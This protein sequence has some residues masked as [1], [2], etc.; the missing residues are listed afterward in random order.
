SGSNLAMNQ[1]LSGENGLYQGISG[2]CAALDKG[3]WDLQE[4][5]I[6]QAL[7]LGIQTLNLQSV[8]WSLIHWEEIADSEGL[9]H[10]VELGIGLLLEEAQQNDPAISEWEFWQSAD[11]FGAE[12]REALKLQEKEIPKDLPLLTNASPK[13]CEGFRK[14]G[15]AEVFST[16]YLG[17]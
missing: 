16:W 6:E 15:R 12:P 2:G 13:S 17:D 9:W 10:P 4:G 8:Q 1:G 5:R 11:D 7:V 3:I 14:R